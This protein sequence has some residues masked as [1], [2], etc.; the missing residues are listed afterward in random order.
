MSKVTF[1]QNVVPRGDAPNK[2]SSNGRT[3]LDKVQLVK[4]SLELLQESGLDALSTRQLATRLGVKSPALYWHVRSKNELLA[5]VADALCGQM[6]LPT[7][8]VSPRQRLEVIAWEYRRVLLRYRDAPRLMSEQPPTG[9]H[10]MK[11]YDAAV[12]ALR[13][14]GLPIAEAVAMATFYRNFLLGMIA[15]EARQAPANDARRLPPASALG[16]ELSH[17]GEDL[18]DYPNLRG[19]SEVLTTI[20]PEDLF[21]T[22]L[23]VILDGM[24]QFAPSRGGGAPGKGPPEGPV[25]TLLLPSRE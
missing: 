12:G 19:A 20:V 15:E 9:P 4:A 13:D 6:T 17:M 18:R 23:K 10:R 7:P 16:V 5:L 14:A 25:G 2:P 24:D 3:G 11:L 22:G 21:R 8:P 1:E